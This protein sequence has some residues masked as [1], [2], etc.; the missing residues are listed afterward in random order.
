MEFVD[1]I[2][3]LID[4]LEIRVEQNTEFGPVEEIKVKLVLGGNVISE[5]S[6]NLPTCD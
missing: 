2:E 5:D 3:Y 1:V 4:N 6:C